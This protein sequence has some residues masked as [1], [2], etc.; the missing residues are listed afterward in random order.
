[1]E[2]AKRSGSHMETK[3]KVTLNTKNLPEH[4]PWYDIFDGLAQTWILKNNLKKSK[5]TTVFHILQ[6]LIIMPGEYSLQLSSLTVRAWANVYAGT[7][8]VTS[9]FY[10]NLSFCGGIIYKR[11]LGT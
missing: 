1:M 8:T 2:C 7:I 6:M 4:F 5:F 11:G 10:C 9:V 3:K